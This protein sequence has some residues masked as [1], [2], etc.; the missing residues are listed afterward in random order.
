M[1][2]RCTFRQGGPVPA[3]LLALGNTPQTRFDV[4]YD[5]TYVVFAVLLWKGIVH[6]L[7]VN[8][9]T[10]R[11]NW[12]PSLLFEIVDPRLPAGWELRFP[13]NPQ[14]SPAMVCG[15]P[16]IASEDGCHYID[17]IE[18]ETPALQIFERR[19]AEIEA[20]PVNS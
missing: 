9:T 15:Y 16:E 7:I 2:V 14:M 12:L 6:Y 18:R 11:P 19:R 17:L 3:E 13:D 1:K 5:Q 20:D 8:D 4:V 10:Q